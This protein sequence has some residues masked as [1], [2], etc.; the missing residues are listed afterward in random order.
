MRGTL[1]PH[2]VVQHVHVNNMD[3]SFPCACSQTTVH[4]AHCLCA[5]KTKACVGESSTAAL[6]A[7][8]VL[9][10][11]IRLSMS[12]PQPSEATQ[13][14]DETLHDERH[15]CAKLEK[16]LSRSAAV[17]ESLLSSRQQIV[18]ELELERAEV[19]GLR[20]R[21]RNA[22]E[23]SEAAQRNLKAQLD[24]LT[25]EME[26]LKKEAEARR[27]ALLA[28]STTATARRNSAPEAKTA[29]SSSP[30][31][32]FLTAGFHRSRS[33]SFRGV[34]RLSRRNSKAAKNDGSGKG[35][36]E[37]IASN[38]PTVSS[39]SELPNSGEVSTCDGN[40][41]PLRITGFCPSF[42]IESIDLF[43]NS[44]SKSTGNVIHHAPLSR[45]HSH[46]ATRSPPT[47]PST[48]YRAHTSL[49]ATSSMDMS[50]F[51]RQN[52]PLSN[53][54]QPHGA[55]VRIDA[56]SVGKLTVAELYGIAL[57]MQEAVLEEA[58]ELKDEF[59]IR[60]TLLVEKDRLHKTANHIE[61][62]A[63]T[64]G[65]NFTPTTATHT[66]KHHSAGLQEFVHAHFPSKNHEETPSA[67]RGDGAC[68]QHWNV[69]API[70][71]VSG[72]ANSLKQS[73]KSISALGRTFMQ[74]EPGVHRGSF[75]LPVIRGKKGL[76]RTG[77]IS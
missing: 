9:D 5:R 21:L 6:I 22:E 48:Q 45:S 31:A 23:H 74:A 49:R 36:N 8:K 71:E 7:S 39:V 67:T 55:V 68:A 35:S 56:A 47:A 2:V 50:S 40:T 20:L 29:A 38:M 58:S 60:E 43:S 69:D 52:Q 18:E 65:G 46:M 44:Q 61:A 32:N 15:Y 33:M 24:R 59:T 13:P 34:R 4:T 66:S 19:N 57:K 16:C 41:T 30:D 37:N 25:R 28:L 72:T 17:I 63:C 73:G 14:L 75:R 77:S 64:P 10:D 53:H 42:S 70:T 76:V 26:D 12:M 11:Q 1:L 62:A 3:A 51:C 27:L 54:A